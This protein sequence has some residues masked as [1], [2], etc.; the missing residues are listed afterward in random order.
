M[1]FDARKRDEYAFHRNVPFWMTSG[2]I[3]FASE[4]DAD[5]TIL[6][7]FPTAKWGSGRV[8][9]HGAVCR[10]TTA[11]AGAGA[12]TLDVGEGTVLAANYDDVSMT[13]AGIIVVGDLDEFIPAADITC[14]VVGTYPALT[15]DSVTLWGAGRMKLITPSDVAVPI[16]YCGLTDAGAACTA[17]VARVDLLVSIIPGV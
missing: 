17:G 4:G 3:T 16:V 13:A 11:F 2:E 14:A 6:F 10:V 8:A 1:T 9:V 7:A 5:G 15:G 12:I